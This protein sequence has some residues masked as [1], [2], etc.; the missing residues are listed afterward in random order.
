MKK[1]ISLF[2]IMCLVLLC[3]CSAKNN[4]SQNEEPQPSTS[5]NRTQKQFGLLYCN[6]DSINPYLAKTMVNRQLSSLIFD[7]LVRINNQYK[8]EYVLAK[9]IERNEKVCTVTLK[10]A[11]FSDGSRVTADDVEY[12]YLLAKESDTYYASALNSIALITVESSDTISITLKKADPYFENLLDFPIIKKGSDKLTDENKIAL[13]PIGSGRYVPD[14]ANLKL[15]RN[16]SHILGTPNIAEINLVNA[17]DNDVAKYNLESGN[18]SIYST[19]LSDGVIP[20][21]SGNLS[22]ISLNRLIFL[23]LN[24][25]K[26]LFK[27][28]QFRY[29]LSACVDRANLCQNSYF[30]YATP[31]TGIFNP[32]FEDAKGV[33]NISSSS[34]TEIMV[35]YLKSIGY[36]NKDEEGYFV[37]SKGKRLEFGLVYYNGNSRRAELAKQLANQFKTIGIS[38]VEKPM[39]WKE[40][41]SSLRN[42]WFDL[43]IAEARVPANMDITELVT[44]GG[45]LAYGLLEPESNTTEDETQ[46]D[47]TQQDETNQETLNHLNTAKA[48]K[49]F[50]NGEYSLTDIINAFNA[51][52]P[53]IPIC[54]TLGV[55]VC[56]TSL[57]IENVSSASD[58]YFGISNTK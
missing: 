16:Q 51:E 32:V 1:V 58:A 30:T 33:Q 38:I 6:G 8:P 47:E 25:N 29:A 36:N 52:M 41:T 27:N 23:G 37:N 20:P 56:D 19:D 26:A 5:D 31:A 49:G 3:S 18:V 54:Y 13:P 39:E 10:N 24:H 34:D 14:F 22:T 45:S 12:S 43:Y 55:T 4:P 15:Y 48:V 42:G 50:Y 17:P 57:T 7:P 44:P 35:A 53:L 28:E 11:L 9:S 2:L 21:M 40:Y 46:Q